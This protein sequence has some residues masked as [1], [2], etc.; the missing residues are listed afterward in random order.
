MVKRKRSN[1]EKANIAIE[2]L[3]EGRTIVDQ[4]KII[5]I[6]Y[7]LLSEDWCLRDKYVLDKLGASGV[8]FGLVGVA[9]GTVGQ[10]LWAVKLCLLFIGAY[11]S[12]VLSISVAKDTYYR[13]G[14]EQLLRFLS[15]ELG[16]SNTLKEMQDKEGFPDSLKK[17]NL[18]FTRK[19]NMESEQSSLKNM[20]WLINWLVKRNTFGW[21]LRFYIFTFL[22]FTVLFITIICEQIW[23][24]ELPI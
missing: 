13:D 12:L 5:K 7:E 23:D 10:N 14:T 19:I 16:I 4:E 22:V 17:A 9:L 18:Q 8:L 24:W 1:K 20:G 2:A 15:K 3:K 21:I 6:E 11:F